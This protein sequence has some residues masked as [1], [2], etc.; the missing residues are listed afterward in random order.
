MKGNLLWRAILI[1]VVILAAGLS[2]YPLDE[3]INLGLDLQ[4]GMHLVLRVETDDALR[5]ETDKDME[6]MRLQLQDEGIAGVTA[7][8]TGDTQFEL[9]NVPTDSRSVVREQSNRYLGE[10]WSFDASGETLTFDMDAAYRQQLRDQSVTQAEQTIRNRIDSLGVSEPV[11]ARQGIGGQGDRLVVQLPGVDDPD[12]VRDIIKSTA[13][14]EFRFAHP[15]VGAAASRDELLQAF[16]GSLPSDY[17]VFA[18]IQ[19]D[20]NG[21]EISRIFWPVEARRVITGRDLRTANPSKDQFGQDVVS[22]QLTPEGADIFGEETA[23]N[24]G[25]PLAII[26]DGV[27]QS[28]PSIRDRITDSGQI[29]GSYTTEQVTDLALVLRSGALP[30]GIEYLE[31]RTVGPSLGQDSIEKGLRAILI[32]AGLVVLMM[33]LVYKFSGVNAV[34]ALTLNVVLVL[35]AL[36]ALGAVLTLPGIAGIVLTI[37][38]AVDANVLIFER[39]REELRTGRTVKSA[40]EAGFAKA[41]STILDANITTLIAAIFLFQFGTGPIRGFAVTLSI[42]IL[43]SL[44]TAVFVSRFIFDFVLSRQQRVE[45]LSI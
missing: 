33:L 38:M 45:R 3:K 9:S 7:R 30:A 32:G 15:N 35:G 44:F 24:I 34:V 42:G 18:E 17:E 14:L 31:E 37:G 36:A 2:A 21:E 5:S 8:R 40:I 39:I 28:A 20:I 26:L 4:G 23:A 13:F 41:L 6:R 19:R 27:V 25:R 12:R 16:G 43:A 22:F 10:G 11:I 1:G 29:S